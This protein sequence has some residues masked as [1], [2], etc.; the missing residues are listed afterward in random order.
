MMH[1]EYFHNNQFI[2]DEALRRELW[3][4]AHLAAYYRDLTARWKLQHPKKYKITCSQ[5]RGGSHLEPENS[6]FENDSD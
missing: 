3:A 2:Q 1:V 6:D 5:L 4:P